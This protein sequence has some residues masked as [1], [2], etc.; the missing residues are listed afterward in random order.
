[1]QRE[2]DGRSWMGESMSV[3]WPS[4]KP[5]LPLSW[6]AH[7]CSPS[8]RFSPMAP[9]RPSVD[10][11]LADFLVYIKEHLRRTFKAKYVDGEILWKTLFSD[12]HLVMP[13]SPGRN[14]DDRFRHAAAKSGIVD[15]QRSHTVQTVSA[16]EVRMFA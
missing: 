6:Q 3:V 14:V 2:K 5:G 12:L 15:R 4:T 16:L 7:L 11:V 13:V 9:L 8:Q 1:V 10:V